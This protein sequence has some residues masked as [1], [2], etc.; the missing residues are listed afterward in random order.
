MLEQP[1]SMP[2]SVCPRDGYLPLFSVAGS[3]YLC[4]EHLQAWQR[5]CER[6]GVP[7]VQDKARNDAFTKWSWEEKKEAKP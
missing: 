7:F 3:P 6:V 1:P 4:R 2:C 5:Y